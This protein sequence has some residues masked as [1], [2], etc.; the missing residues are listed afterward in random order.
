MAI[1]NRKLMF[2][3]GAAM[4]VAASPAFAG[5]GQPSPWQMT[6]QNAATPIM[7]QITSF[8]NFV[9]VII[10]LIALFVMGL[11]IYVMS[12]FNDGDSGFDL[13][14]DRNPLLP[15]AFRPIRFPQGRSHRNRHR[16]PVVLDLRIS[17]SGHHLRLDHRA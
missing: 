3:S 12:R 2:V 11:L 5:E 13:G 8:H 14:G 16:Q 7:E 9:T 10:T 4:L 17:G 15:L 6:F 1:L